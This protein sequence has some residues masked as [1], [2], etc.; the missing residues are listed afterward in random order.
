M[1]WGHFL[2]RLLSESILLS[3]LLPG[4]E[5]SRISQPPLQLDIAVFPSPGQQNTKE[6][7]MGPG[8]QDISLGFSRAVST[9]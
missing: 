3:L 6:E 5:R 8:P 4:R 2:K 1:L 7:G 9:P